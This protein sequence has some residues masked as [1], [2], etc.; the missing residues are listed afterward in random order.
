M[1]RHKWDVAGAPADSPQ[2]QAMLDNHGEPFGVVQ[3]TMQTREGELVAVPYVFVR[4]KRS[5][6]EKPRVRVPEGL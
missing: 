5:P 4:T 1:T 2:L 3:M 6:I